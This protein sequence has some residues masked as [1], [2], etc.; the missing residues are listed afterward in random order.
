MGLGAGRRAAPASVRQP[1]PDDPPTDL[2]HVAPADIVWYPGHVM[3]SMGLD[4]AV[5]DASDYGTDVRMMVVKPER[6]ARY[7]IGSPIGP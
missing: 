4:G 1:D 6:F 3:M 2:T 7:K 5:V